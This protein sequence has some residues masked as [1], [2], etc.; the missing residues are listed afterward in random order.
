M[1]AACAMTDHRSVGVGAGSRVRLRKVNHS[2][3]S[4]VVLTTSAPS[5]R[6]ALPCAGAR[7]AIT[8]HRRRRGRAS[9]PSAAARKLPAVCAIMAPPS[10]GDGVISGRLHHHCKSFRPSHKCLPTLQPHLKP[11]GSHCRQLR[12]TKLD[13]IESLRYCLQSGDV[14]S[15]SPDLA[16]QLAARQASGQSSS[17]WNSVETHAGPAWAFLCGA[18]LT[19]IPDSLP[20][21]L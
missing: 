7:T 5:G 18:L 6:T 4:V 11:E 10:A 9:R 8:N 14:I 3:L 2:L 1:F 16:V 13:E 15:L 19:W 20:S 17:G 12:P 21:L